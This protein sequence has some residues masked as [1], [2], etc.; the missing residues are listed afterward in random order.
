M[1]RAIGSVDFKRARQLAEQHELRDSWWVCEDYSIRGGEIVAT[2][3]YPRFGFDDG[4]FEVLES[5]KEQHRHWRSYRPLQE[6]PDLFLKLAY[7]YEQENFSQAALAFSRRY[8]VLGGSN[9][10]WSMEKERVSLYSF[11][12]ESRRAWLILKLYEAVL[13]RDGGT[14]ESLL[15]DHAREVLGAPAL[16]FD[17]MPPE[18]RS[19]P[20]NPALEKCSDALYET[21]KAVEDSIQILCRPTIVRKKGTPPLDTSGFRRGWRF[22]NLL[23]AAYL[24][25][26]WLITSDDE[27]S[28]CKYCRRIMALS[29]VHMNGRKQRTDKKFCNAACRQAAHRVKKQANS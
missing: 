10:Q 23:G 17:D 6:A 4:T 3:S 13:N 27:L 22:C 5:W 29:Q 24:Q 14:A 9:S 21:T 25:A 26:F 2:Y 1:Q 15:Y 20:N 18:I 19:F 16:D 12:Q 8:G 11:E 28:R 7:L